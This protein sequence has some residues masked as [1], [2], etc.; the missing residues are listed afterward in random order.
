MRPGLYCYLTMRRV[1]AISLMML[2]SWTL[3]AP[4]FAL[5]ADAKLPACCRRNG[6]HY[7]MMRM[8]ERRAGQQRGFMSV[9][10]K[11]SCFPVGICAAYS[12]VFKPEAE[13]QFYADVVRHPAIALQSV[14]IYRISSLGSH[15]KRGP[16]LA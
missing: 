4:L 1:I 16:P 13:G 9:S 7:C 3:I 8:M 2:F 14:A 6:K 15:Q 11:C 5:D 12:P 10:E